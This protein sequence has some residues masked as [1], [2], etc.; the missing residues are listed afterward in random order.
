METSYHVGIALERR[1]MN[2]VASSK[3]FNK[4]CDRVIYVTDLPAHLI[5]IPVAVFAASVSIYLLLYRSSVRRLEEPETGGPVL[6]H[7]E[8]EM[9]RR[10]LSALKGS[11][12]LNEVIGRLRKARREAE[13]IL[14]GLGRGQES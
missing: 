3:G 6:S 8:V 12:D 9:L 11:T 10:E 14:E 2:R 13:E 7:E 1:R 4:I 5:L